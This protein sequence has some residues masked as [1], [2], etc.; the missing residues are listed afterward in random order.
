[1]I[2]E[3]EDD[4]YGAELK[5]IILGYIRPEMNY[6]SMGKLLHCISGRSPLSKFCF[7]T[8]SNTFASKK[9]GSNYEL[10]F[11]QR[12]IFPIVAIF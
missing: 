12:P 8:V 1:M 2:H 5:L 9:Y 11:D 6:S 10:N 4:F 3:F 7:P